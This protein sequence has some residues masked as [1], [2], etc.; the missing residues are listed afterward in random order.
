MVKGYKAFNKDWTCLGFQYEVGKTYEMNGDIEMCER[1]FHFCENMK[2]C[3]RF[4]PFSEDTRI[5]E[6]RAEGEVKKDGIKCVTDKITIIREIMWDDVIKSRNTGHYNTG[7]WNTGDRNTGS[8]NTGTGNTGDWNTGDR[9]T[10]SS[11]TGN[12]NAGNRNTGDYNTG[13]RNTGSYNTG[14]CNTGNY[15]TG[16]YNT[17]DWNKSFFN[18][19]CFNTVCANFMLFNKPSDMLFIDWMDS[20]ARGLLNQIPKL[21]VE[22][23]DQSD[24]TNDEKNA[25]PTYETTHGYL[26]VLDRSDCAQIWW[27]SLDEDDCNIIKEIPNF[28]A[29]IFYECTGIRV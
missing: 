24:M 16:Y 7:D 27:D 17:G 18:T 4:Y 8:R 13:N 3:Y 25:H 12:Y 20:K 11:N 1:G 6:V 14:D 10:G 28:D 26:K 9:N 2:D 15:N 22:W 21:V 19:G 23:V 29:D 5:A